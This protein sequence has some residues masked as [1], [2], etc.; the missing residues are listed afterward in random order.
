MQFNDFFQ[1]EYIQILGTSSNI[2][3]PLSAHTLSIVPIGSG[4]GGD[5]A[6][7]RVEAF[8]DGDG[9]ESRGQFAVVLL[10]TSE[11]SEG[12]AFSL[13]AQTV[14]SGEIVVRSRV[15]FP[16]LLAK[17]NSLRKRCRKNEGHGAFR[18]K[19]VVAIIGF[20]VER[21]RFSNR[22]V[23]RDKQNCERV[24]SASSQRQCSNGKI[25]VNSNG[26]IKEAFEVIRL[27]QQLGV[28]FGNLKE[29]F[30]QQIVELELRD[31]EGQARGRR[32]L[33]PFNSGRWSRA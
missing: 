33:S 15:S 27:G 18:R 9:S 8:E 16:L 26:I 29:A 28:N 7:N 31:G 30:L 4:Q 19:V 21:P 23:V 13:S 24:K 20:S 22:V 5:H 14:C 1:V 12:R 3:S 32:A 17:L 11:P 6:G 2:V 10:I 25:E